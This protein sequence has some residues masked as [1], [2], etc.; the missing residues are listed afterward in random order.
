MEIKD[1]I[2]FCDDMTCDDCPFNKYLPEVEFEETECYFETL[3]CWW[4]ENEIERRLK[5]YGEKEN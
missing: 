3:P 4:N 2:K 1:I 5:N